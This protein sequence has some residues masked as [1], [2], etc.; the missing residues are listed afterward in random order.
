MSYTLEFLTN[1][2][3][4]ISDLSEVYGASYIKLSEKYKGKREMALYTPEYFRGRLE[5]FAEDKESMTF[6]ISDEDRAVGFARFSPIP[7]VYKSM[8]KGLSIHLEKG[9]MDGF[10]YQWLREVRMRKSPDYTDRT[11]MLNQIYLAPDAQHKGL[12]TQVFA[13]V[14]PQMEEKYDNIVVEFNLKNAKGIRF[15]KSMGFEVAGITQDLDHILP[16]KNEWGRKMC[17]SNVGI[18]DAP[19]QTVREN[20]VRKLAQHNL[21]LLRFRKQNER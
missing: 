12:G 7:D 18:A 1:N 3:E 19:I 2:P 20:A 16:T 5:R 14:L 11:V 6:V 13:S 15:Y 9:E 8:P 17:V 21:P 4:Q 10:E